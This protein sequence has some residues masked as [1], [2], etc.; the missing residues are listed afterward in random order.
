MVK[1]N[2]PKNKEK[3]ENS[4][5]IKNNTDIVERK[6]SKQTILCVGEY[7]T[8]IILQ[9]ISQIE[10]DDFAYPVFISKF[11]NDVE[12]WSQAMINQNNILGLEKNVDTHFWHQVLPSFSEDNDLMEKLNNR[13]ID[14]IK[15]A[16][17]LSSLWDGLG[18]ALTPTLISQFKE[19]NTNSV[20]FGILPSQLQPSDA[21]FNAFSS[22]G[23][24]LSKD[25][26][27]FV[28]LDRDQLEKFVGID[29]NGSLIKGNAVV[30]FLL[31][32]IQQKKS[33]IE[34]ISELTRAFNIRTY[35]VLIASGASIG[36]YGS[37]ENILSA[38]LSRPLLNFKLS[39]ASIIYVIVRMPVRLKNILTKNKIELS[40]ANWFKEKMELNSIQ[41]SEP[42][43]RD[44]E[45]DRIDIALFIGG[46]DLAD[47][48]TPIMKK[49]K[50]LKNNA[51]KKGLIKKKDWEVIVKELIPN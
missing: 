23:L 35:S 34:E 8:K 14:K 39:N 28:L 38:T 30:N 25:F 15:G 27:S 18:S 29:R 20:A 24:C 19:S 12:E 4:N 33:F 47:I 7:T 51:I 5:I 21:H 43:Y 49:I 36:V 13:S 9:N 2:K 31:D 37:L 26:A 48:F 45:G 11:S 50:P 17:I 44:Y 46:F 16:L 3:P 32:L 22:V 10:K 6:N 41:I 1:K 40:L 42:I